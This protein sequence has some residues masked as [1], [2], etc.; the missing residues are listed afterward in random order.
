M[1]LAWLFAL[2]KA[3]Y[4]ILVFNRG[5]RNVPLWEVYGTAIGL[6]LRLCA[7]ARTAAS[8]PQQLRL[9]K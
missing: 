5:T 1:Q 9:S 2:T 8:E 6:L 4:K 7:N 3:E